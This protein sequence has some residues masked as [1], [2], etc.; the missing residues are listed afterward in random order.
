MCAADLSDNSNTSLAFAA[1]D[2]RQMVHNALRH[3]GMLGKAVS[4]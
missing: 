2:L 1:Q 3:R 4:I